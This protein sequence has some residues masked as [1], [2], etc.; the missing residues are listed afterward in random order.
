MRAA[1]DKKILSRDIDVEKSYCFQPYS[2]TP[3]GTSP[4]FFY[5][6]LSEEVSVVPKVNIPPSVYFL[7]AIVAQALLPSKLEGKGRIAS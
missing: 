7:I 1:D 6:E 4:V 2:S 3:Y 5:S